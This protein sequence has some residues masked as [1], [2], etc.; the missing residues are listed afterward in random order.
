MSEVV[1]LVVVFSLSR[2]AA[3]KNIS[4]VPVSGSNQLYV[5]RGINEL[6]EMYYFVQG[7]CRNTRIKD[8]ELL[9]MVFR[10]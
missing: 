5:S 1:V 2:I 7:V 9:N 4:N 3:A 6:Q 10:I 8:P